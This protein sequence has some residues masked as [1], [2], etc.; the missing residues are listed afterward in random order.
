MK[1]VLCPLLLICIIRLAAA[2]QLYHLNTLQTQLKASHSDTGRINVLL[3]LADYEILKPGEYKIDLDSAS[4]FIQMAKKLNQNAHSPESAGYITMMESDLAKEH[5]DRL[6]GINLME[7]AI[8]QLSATSNKCLLGEAYQGLSDFYDFLDPKQLSLKERYLERAA[9]L[10]KAG[11]FIDKEAYCDKTISEIVLDDTLALQKILEAMKLYQSIKYKKMQGVYDDVATCYAMRSDLRQSLKY[12][13]KALNSAKE[14]ADSGGTL[15][16]IYNHL[17]MTYHDLDDYKSSIEYYRSGL[18]AA[19][20]NKDLESE[21][22]IILNLCNAYFHEKEYNEARSLLDE[23]LKLNIS[24]TKTQTRVAVFADEVGFF[25]SLKSFENARQA[26]MKL[27]PLL[28]RNDFD[29]SLR[30]VAYNGLVSYYLDSHQ[31]TDAEKYLKI[32]D[33]QPHNQPLVDMRTKEAF[34]FRLDTALH[35]YKAANNHLISELMLADSIN[36]MSRSKAIQSLQIQFKTKEKESQIL[37]LEKNSRLKSEN[38]RQ[39][40][41]VRNYTIGSSVLLLIIASLL[42][43]QNLLKQRSSITISNKNM[44]LQRLLDEK[45]WLLKEVHHRVKNNLQTVISLLESQAMYL[46]NDA[47]K[48]IENSRHRIYAMSLIHQKLYQNDDIKVVNMNVYLAEFVEY[49][50]ESFGSPGHIHVTLDADDIN[51]G[52]GQ[53]IPV[54]LIINEAVNNAFKYAFPT[55]KDGEIAIVLKK[56]AN[57]IY[58]SVTDN[59]IGFKQQVSQESSSLGLELIKGLTLDLRGTITFESCAGTCIRIRFMI[60]RIGVP[61]DEDGLFILAP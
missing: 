9:D 11:G 10:F 38:L 8:R 23:L 49:L 30:E 15:V 31:L 54:S 28:N 33:S 40:N 26:S 45:E 25:S 16:E 12:E 59:G 24:T 55:Q 2:Q 50:Q 60:E 61:A 17:G 34:W 37:L 20:L 21:I 56:L 3:N 7:K 32:M 22:Y 43:R 19:Q 27:I 58:L 53:A 13:L 51:L 29:E 36:Q 39:S 47:L 41:V 4:S 48:A 14:Q 1:K 52:A 35:R 44:L 6:T 5:K 42:Y 57:E 46:E 18:A